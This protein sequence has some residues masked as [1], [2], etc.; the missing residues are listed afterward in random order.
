[1]NRMEWHALDKEKVFE[2]FKSSEQG[3]SD[4]EVKKRLEE[5]GPNELV[6]KRKIPPIMIFLNQFKDFMIIVLVGA[7]IVSGFVGDVADTII[8]LVIVLLNA[9]VGFIQEYRAEKA[10]EALKKMA[11][12]QAKLVRQGHQTMKPSAEV[13]PGDIVVLEAGD[14]V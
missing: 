6:E 7:A 8:I 4:D 5:N 9:I 3:L 1:M 13:V 2:E 14:V 10:M 11:A 12:P